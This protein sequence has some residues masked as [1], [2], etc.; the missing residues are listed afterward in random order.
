RRIT[1]H[2]RHSLCRSV[3]LATIDDK[4]AVYLF[5]IRFRGRYQWQ[6][7]LPG[8]DVW[9]WYTGGLQKSRREVGERHK[10]VEHLAWLYLVAPADGQRHPRSPV[11]Q[12][13][14]AP[15]E[16]HAMV[17]RHDDDRV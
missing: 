3:T 6:Q 14:F 11:V 5:R 15:R 7:R 16:G 12:V 17:A 8:H 2:R 13:S 1:P 4:V 10:L 9:Y